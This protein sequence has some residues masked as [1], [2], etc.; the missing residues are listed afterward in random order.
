MSA[1]STLAKNKLD[2]ECG[3][4]LGLLRYGERSAQDLVNAS[5]Q[6]GRKLSQ[7]TVNR[8]LRILRSRGF[9]E[10]HA[11]RD[12]SARKLI[13]RL[14]PGGMGIAQSLGA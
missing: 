9:I 3:L 12:G 6:E 8:R 10:S 1:L 11:G 14:T 13:H 7:D 5:S 2:V 4:I